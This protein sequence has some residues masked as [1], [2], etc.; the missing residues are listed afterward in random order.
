MGVGEEAGGQTVTHGVSEIEGAVMKCGDMV[1]FRAT[2]TL[3]RVGRVAEIGADGLV[4]LSYRGQLLI[5]RE[6]RFLHPVVHL[7]VRRMHLGERFEHA[8]FLGPDNLPARCVVTA[9][10]GGR[11]HFT[12]ASNWD[13]GDHRGAWHFPQDKADEHVREVAQ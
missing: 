3:T 9:V 10:R 11:V 4:T 12:Y 8:R 2:R 5:P 6:A 13:E 1:W 7:R